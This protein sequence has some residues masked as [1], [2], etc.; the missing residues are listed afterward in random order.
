[1][2]NM[3]ECAAFWLLGADSQGVI[4]APV[5]IVAIPLLLL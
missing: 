2:R 5:N 3:S 1:M 4:R